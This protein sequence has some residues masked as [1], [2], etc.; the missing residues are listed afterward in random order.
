MMNLL[1]SFQKRNRARRPDSLQKAVIPITYTRSEHVCVRVCVFLFLRV[2]PRVTEGEVLRHTL[3]FL[4]NKQASISRC[5]LNTT[6]TQQT[7]SIYFQFFSHRLLKLSGAIIWQG[8]NKLTARIFPPPWDIPINFLELEQTADDIFL[9]FLFVFF[10]P[11]YFSS[12][13]STFL[14]SA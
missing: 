10:Y 4:H 9:F 1:K 3:I 13:L 2:A 5:R 11:M 8:T 12:N 6:S 14:T 7:I